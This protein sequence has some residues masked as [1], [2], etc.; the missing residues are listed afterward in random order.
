MD[1]GGAYGGQED[2]RR[3]AAKPAAHLD[4]GDQGDEQH[5]DVSKRHLG[6]VIRDA[7][8]VTVPKECRKSRKAP[9]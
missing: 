1:D 8:L 6:F 3:I 2:P 9:N 4:H 5:E 7:Y